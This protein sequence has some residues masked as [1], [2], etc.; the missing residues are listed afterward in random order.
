MDAQFVKLAKPKRNLGLG[1]WGHLLSDRLQIPPLAHTRIPFGLEV[2]DIQ[3]CLLQNPK[4]LFPYEFPLIPTS[5]N[6]F[7]L[8]FHIQDT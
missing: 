8:L 3:Q 4:L 1:V 2:G 5:L 6:S 7:P